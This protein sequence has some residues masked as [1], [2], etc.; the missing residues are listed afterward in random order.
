MAAAPKTRRRFET[1]I[2]GTV[3]IPMAAIG[4]PF[5]VFMPHYYATDLGIGLEVVGLIF[6]AVRFWDMA[7]DPVMGILVD[8]YPTRFG[9]IR[10]WML[11]SVPILILAGC[12]LYMPP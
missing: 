12:A 10:H 3:G 7:S 5:A 2:Y 6:M 1:Q 8:K 9:R 11:A 4:L